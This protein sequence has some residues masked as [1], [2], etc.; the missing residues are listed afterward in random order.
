MFRSFKDTPLPT[1]T[2]KYNAWAKDRKSLGITPYSQE[3]EDGKG[4]RGGEG[5]REINEK[6]K[7]EWEEDQKVI[8]YDGIAIDEIILTTPISIPHSPL[9]LY[10]YL[11]NI[12]CG[13][14]PH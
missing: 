11:Y 2:H 4:G 10:I 12:V 1:P 7:Q 8:N 9:M 3:E 5:K 14:D 13:E 6:E